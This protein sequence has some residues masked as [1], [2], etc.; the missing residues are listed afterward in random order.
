[1]SRKGLLRLLF[2][3][4]LLLSGCW[5]RT[6]LNELGI[7]AATAFDKEGETW[8]MSYQVIVPSAM[9]TGQGGAGNG[10]SSKP[11]VHVFTNRGASIR[12]A[13][14]MSYMESPRRLYFAHTDVLVLGIEAAKAGIDEVLDLYFRNNDARETVLVTITDGKASDILKKLIPAENLPGTALS[15]MLRKESA[16]SSRLP[17]IK[18]Y[19]LAQRMTSDSAAAGV[20]EIKFTG[21]IKGE[22]ESLDDEKRTSAPGTLL[23]NRLGVFQGDRFIGWLN[24]RESFGV[25]WLTDQ[26]KGSTIAFSSDRKNE[27]GKQNSIR[28]TLAK[29]KVTP[30]KTGNH[31]KMKVEVNLSGV[32]LEAGT[33]QDLLK[34]ESISKLEQDLEKEVT[35]IIDTGWKA[36]KRIGV[37]LPGFADKIHRKYPKDWKKIKETW[38]EDFKKV[39]LD[40]QVKAKIQRPGL[41]KKSFRANH[42]GSSKAGK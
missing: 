28:I 40:V 25:S 4:S 9:A 2:L 3:S 29:T 10:G 35:G 5:N 42:E 26:V 13:A 14:D 22:M 18:V 37:D 6:E 21:N 20:P 41:L 27:S 19:Q 30:E 38:K 15:E 16:F 7:T 34:P 1:M 33:N 31:F 39:E 23:L 36:S 24:R 32:L 11:S 12:E 8:V 17:S